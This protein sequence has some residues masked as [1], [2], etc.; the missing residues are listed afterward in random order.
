MTDQFLSTEDLQAIM[1]HIEHLEQQIKLTNE[2]LALEAEYSRRV[3][4][5]LRLMDKQSIDPHNVFSVLCDVRTALLSDSPERQQE[6]M[7]RVRQA[8]NDWPMVVMLH[9]EHDKRSS[10]IKA[11]KARIQEVTP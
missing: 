6:L 4:L 5:A 2:Q 7:E 8:M 3:E 10:V 1:Q 11:L 9:D